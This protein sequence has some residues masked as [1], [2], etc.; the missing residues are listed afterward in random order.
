[1]ET[2]GFNGAARCQQ[3]EETS[4]GNQQRPAIGGTQAIQPSVTPP[5]DGRAEDH[6]PPGGNSKNVEQQV[7]NPG[8]RTAGRVVQGCREDRTRPA[9]ILR[10]IAEQ[11]QRQEAGEHNKGK[12]ARLLQDDGNFLWQRARCLTP[13]CSSFGRQGNRQEKM[14]RGLY[15]P[16]ARGSGSTFVKDDQA[17]IDLD[18]ATGFQ[19]LHHPAD[20]LA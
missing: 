1:M 13:A 14:K 15:P 17:I 8:T 19:I 5:D 20:H 11:G 10:V 12:P 16:P 4:E 7:G 18:I 3:D 6:P 2:Q 9:R